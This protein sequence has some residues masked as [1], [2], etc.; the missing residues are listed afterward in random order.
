MARPAT[1]A[2]L[3]A[4][5]DFLAKIEDGS[6]RNERRR[7]LW[8]MGAPAFELLDVNEDLSKESAAAV[9]EIAAICAEAGAHQKAVSLSRAA[10]EKDKHVLHRVRYMGLTQCLAWFA[11]DL[12]KDFAAEMPLI[13]QL[14][15][16]RGATA[17]ILADSG[18]T[19]C[20]VGNSPCLLGKGRGAEIDGH[21]L[22]L[23]FNNFETLD[24]EQDFGRKTDIWVRG[25]QKSVWR[26]DGRKPKSMIVAGSPMFWRM[27]NGQYFAA[28]CALANL[29]AEEVEPRTYYGAARQIGA[30]PSSGLLV[31]WW[32]ICLRG[33]FQGVTIAG[34]DPGGQKEGLTHYFP[35]PPRLTPVPH[36]WAAEAEVLSLWQRRFGGDRTLRISTSPSLTNSH[37]KEEAGTGTGPAWLRRLFHSKP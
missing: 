34:F 11:P 19:V 24:Y 2:A 12:V 17:N 27:K 35:R 1:I 15:G 30:P 10:V 6:A 29:Q 21:D 37:D 25:R 33:S 20:V 18:K 31:I 16:A 9:L 36:N 13:K 3:T 32:L 8:H 23:R 22:V 28:D 5:R 7:W 4:P 26:Y 14:V